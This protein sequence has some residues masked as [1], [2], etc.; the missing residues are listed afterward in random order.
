MYKYTHTAYGQNVTNSRKTARDLRS[1][2]G[3]VCV[4]VVINSGVT[5]IGVTL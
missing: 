5:K 1:S 4:S 2:T 3:K